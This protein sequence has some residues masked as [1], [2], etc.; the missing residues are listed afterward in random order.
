MAGD[1]QELVR[2]T[3]QRLALGDVPPL[4]HDA[5]DGALGIEH[6]MRGDVE[7]GDVV[8]RAADLIVPLKEF[9]C[10]GPR[11]R[12]PR[13]LRRTLRLGK[14]RR[15]PEWL[16]HRL[17]TRRSGEFQRHAVRVQRRAVRRRQTAMYYWV[18]P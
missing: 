17:T 11:H 5:R 9:A 15:I 10:G 13:G 7:R 12:L 14:Q 3:L 4:G 1:R 6:R 2:L 16:S 18:P 8:D